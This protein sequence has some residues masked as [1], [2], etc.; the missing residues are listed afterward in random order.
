MTKQHKSASHAAWEGGEAASSGSGRST[1]PYPQS[2]VGARN[3]W[4][5]GYDRTIEEM[6][7]LN[8]RPRLKG[9]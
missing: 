8:R 7:R 4:F 2:D 1:N 3:E 5:A 6:S 9:Y